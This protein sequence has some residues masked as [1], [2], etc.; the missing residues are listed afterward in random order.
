MYSCAYE[1][2]CIN[3]MN[4][5]MCA[6][7]LVCARGGVGWLVRFLLVVGQVCVYERESP[8]KRDSKQKSRLCS[9]G[10]HRHLQGIFKQDTKKKQRQHGHVQIRVG[11]F[12]VKAAT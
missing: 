9:I 12:S 6:H 5:C 2:I 7:K 11:Y 8:C 10:S 3:F 1:N 4:V